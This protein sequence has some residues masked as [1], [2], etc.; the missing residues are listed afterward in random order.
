MKLADEEWV[1]IKRRTRVH[2]PLVGEIEDRTVELMDYSP[3]LDRP[4]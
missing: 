3:K 2:G 4:S 1:E